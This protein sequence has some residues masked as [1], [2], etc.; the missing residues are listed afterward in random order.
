MLRTHRKADSQVNELFSWTGGVLGERL[1]VRFRWVPPEGTRHET[2]GKVASRIGLVDRPRGTT[3]TTIPMQ[4]Q[5]TETEAAELQAL[6]QGRRTTVEQLA[7]EWLGERLLHER[8]RAAGRA[9]PMSPRAREAA[10]QALGG[11]SSPG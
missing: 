5:L 3:L 11:P 6:A 9:W 2:M 8:E 1:V 4:L 10:D 7:S